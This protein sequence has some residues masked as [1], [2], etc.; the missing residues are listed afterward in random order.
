MGAN[1]KEGAF[2]SC[3]KLDCILFI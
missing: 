3:Q 1:E 2:C